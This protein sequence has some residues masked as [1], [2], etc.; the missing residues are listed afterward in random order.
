MSHDNVKIAEKL[1]D[2]GKFSSSEIEIANYILRKKEDILRMSAQEICKETYTSTSSLVQLCRK[3]GLEGFKDFKI[4]YAA[5]LERQI[6]DRGDVNYNFP[7]QSNDSV[8]DIAQKMS[9][10]M[11]NTLNSSYSLLAH[12]YR[13]MSKAVDLIIR[14]RRTALFAMGDSLI[15]GMVF[16]ANMLKIDELVLINS[17]QGEQ[18]VLA[19]ILTEADC[20]I[21]VSYSGN[22]KSVYDQVKILRKHRVPLIVITSNPDSMIGRQA[23]IILK[24]PVTEDKWSKQA[25]FSSQTATEYMLNVLYSCVYVRKFGKSSTMRMKNIEEHSDTRF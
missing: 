18:D 19:D 11:S 14:S 21:I 9:V 5:E 6:E 16:R 1:A 4:R 3:I 10:I 12:N 7:F 24:V 15:K 25:T 22:S 17:L 23:K 8:L 13:E 20:G 2:Q